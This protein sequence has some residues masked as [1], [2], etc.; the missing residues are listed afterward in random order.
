MGERILIIRL[1]A[2]GDV[3]HTLPLASAIKDARPDSRITW[4]VEPAMREVLLGNPDL[5][6]ILTIDTKRWRKNL[7]S[8]GFSALRRDLLAIRNTG[9]DVALDAQG[10]LKSGFLAWASGSHRI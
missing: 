9:A 2:I 8:G 1:G 3:V 7:F 6:E 10:L 5:D 4:A